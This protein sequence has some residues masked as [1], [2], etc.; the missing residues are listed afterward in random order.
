MGIEIEHDRFRTADHDL[1]KARLSEQL[2]ALQVVLARPCFG[3]GVRL[4][5]A[6]LE[7]S[8]VNDAGQ[9]LRLAHEI[10]QAAKTPQ[11]TPAAAPVS[12]GDGRRNHCRS[13]ISKTA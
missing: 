1:F 11:I 9:P 2:Q 13:I 3:Q 7:L 5:G 8:L 4:L 10:V 12:L 6:E